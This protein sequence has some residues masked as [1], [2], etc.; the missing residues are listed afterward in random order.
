[1]QFFSPFMFFFPSMKYSTKIR[2]LRKP[3]RFRAAKSGCSIYLYHCAENSMNFDNNGKQFFLCFYSFFPAMKG[4]TK[5][6]HLREPSL[7]I[8]IFLCHSNQN[9]L[10]GAFILCSCRS[11]VFVFVELFS[12]R[13]DDGGIYLHDQPIRL[14][15]SRYVFNYKFFSSLEREEKEQLYTEVISVYLS[16]ERPLPR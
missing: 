16:Y 9:A 10:Y 12:P 7:G 14:Y 1:M 5:V 3:G 15:P 11:S 2:H 4:S 13:A 6:R 8:F